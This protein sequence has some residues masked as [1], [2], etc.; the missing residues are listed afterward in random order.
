MTWLARLLPYWSTVRSWL[1]STGQWVIGLLH[2]QSTWH[3]WEL[4]A[5]LLLFT[6]GCHQI[7]QNSRQIANA[8]HDS[9][10]VLSATVIEKDKKTEVL[11]SAI[12]LHVSK[13]DSSEALRKRLSCSVDTL[14]ADRLQSVLDS[15]FPAPRTGSRLPDPPGS[16]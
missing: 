11:I 14:P 13:T 15:L 5:I 10:S 1:V 3:T 9:I 7:G 2:R 6:R 8:R 4:L 12:S 16:R